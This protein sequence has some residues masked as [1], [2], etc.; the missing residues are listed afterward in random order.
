[1]RSDGIYALNVIDYPP[2]RLIRAELATV[3]DVFPH[4]ALIAPDDAIE[5]RTGS[6]FVLVASMRPLPVEAVRAA[7]AEVPRPASVLDGEPLAEFRGDA[8]VLTDDYA[9]VDQLL[10]RL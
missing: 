8:A 5:G 10:N 6:N 2:G 1:M 3:M 9:P 7:V 4:V